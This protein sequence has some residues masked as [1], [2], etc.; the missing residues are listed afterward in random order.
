M[1]L[2]AVSEK[3]DATGWLEKK[4]VTQQVKIILYRNEKIYIFKM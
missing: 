4:I 1:I 2:A 3:Q